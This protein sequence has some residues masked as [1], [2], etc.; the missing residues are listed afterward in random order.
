MPD[1]PRK[2]YQVY[3]LE[4]LR[5]A[6]RDLYDAADKV[7]Q[8]LQRVGDYGLDELGIDPA[9]FWRSIQAHRM[10][11]TV[12]KGI[13]SGTSD[14]LFLIRNF[15]HEMSMLIPHQKEQSCQESSDFKNSVPSQSEPSSP[16]TTP[17]V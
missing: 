5:K 7:E 6:V 12:P 13:S 9:A 16:N 14:G 2:D 8:A 17:V 3:G 4:S 1:F 11:G 10:R 15:A